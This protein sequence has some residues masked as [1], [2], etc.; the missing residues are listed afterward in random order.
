MSWQVFLSDLLVTVR[1]PEVDHSPATKFVAI[2]TA[3]PLIVNQVVALGAAVPDLRI[4]HDCGWRF[5]FLSPL[6]CHG[7]EAQRLDK[8]SQYG[9]LP[10]G[11]V[12]LDER[13]VQRYQPP[14]VVRDRNVPRRRFVSDAV[15]QLDGHAAHKPVFPGHEIASSAIAI[16]SMGSPSAASAAAA[17]S[18]ATAALAPAATA[19]ATA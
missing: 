5:H 18:A 16:R 2:G 9:R 15:A 12:S 10:R 7:R 14:Q 4:D 8:P 1:A 6:P 19:A 13:R 11:T 17:A 3:P